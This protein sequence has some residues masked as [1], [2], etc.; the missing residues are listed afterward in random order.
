MDCVPEM[1][2]DDTEESNH[3][4]GRVPSISDDTAEHSQVFDCKLFLEQLKSGKPMADE[5]MLEHLRFFYNRSN[6]NDEFLI[7]KVMGNSVHYK[8]V[9]LSLAYNIYLF[10]SSI[11]PVQL[12]GFSVVTVSVKSKTMLSQSSQVLRAKYK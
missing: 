8:R 4:V 2:S 7:E 10:A 5:Q 12:Q 11:N 3:S 1:S 6:E 9:G